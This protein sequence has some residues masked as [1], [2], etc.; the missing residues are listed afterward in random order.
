MSSSPQ[1][2][3][4]EALEMPSADRGRLAALLIE[5]LDSEKDDDAEQQWSE[6]LQRRLQDIDEGRVQL[7]S[8]SE[9]RR[10]LQENDDAAG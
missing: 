6:E 1:E 2:L 8:W 7:I 5:S 4:T 10:R 3:L 9:V